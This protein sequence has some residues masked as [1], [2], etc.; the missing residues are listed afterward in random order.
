MWLVTISTLG[1]LSIDGIGKSSLTWLLRSKLTGSLFMKASM[2]EVW[3][4]AILLAWKTFPPINP[5]IPLGPSWSST[6]AAAR[7]RFSGPSA[8]GW[9][10]GN[11]AP[12]ITTFLPAVFAKCPQTSSRKSAVSSMVSVPWVTTT[13]TIWGSWS[14][15][16]TSWPSWVNK[17]S[18]ISQLSILDNCLFFIDNLLL[19][20][21]ERVSIG[22]WPAR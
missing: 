8:L 20:C 14:A 9:S 5:K 11:M 19:I 21:P 13:P 12:V 3:R 6:R 22:T 15:W 7:L 4:F 16:T 1:Q 2:L 17:D 10:A 18:V